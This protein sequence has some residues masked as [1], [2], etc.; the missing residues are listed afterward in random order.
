MVGASFTVAAVAQ[1]LRSK[2]GITAVGNAQ[3]STAQSQFGGSSALFDASAD[4]LVITNTDDLNTGT[5]DFTL[6]FWMRP[7]SRATNFPV[8]I[9]NRA[10]QAGCIQ[11]T[12]R[13][14][15]N[16][17]KLQVWV[18]NY[19]NAD[20]MFVSTTT[21]ANNTWY[22]IAVSRSGSSWR[23]F[24]NGTQEGSTVTYSGDATVGANNFAA[25]GNDATNTSVTQWN[26]YI[27]EVRWSKTARYTSNFTPSTTAFVNDANTLFL[28][29]ANGTDAS[30]FFEDDNGVRAQVGIGASGTVVTSTTQSKFGGTS[31]YFDGG[32]TDH[33]LT[34]TDAPN[35]GSGNFT[36]EFWIYPYTNSAGNSNGVVTKRVVGN[37]GA[38]AWG[39]RW[40]DSGTRTIVW[41]NIISPVTT[42]T[43]SANPFNYNAWSHWAFVRNGSTLT[44]YVNGTS[45]GSGS[46]SIDFTNSEPIRLGWWGTGTTTI[47]AYVD[48]IRISNSARYTT[49]FTPSTTP[50]TNDANTVLLIHANG[51]NASTVFRDDNGARAPK[52]IQ[53]I[54]NAQIDT[55]QSKFGG[56]SLL[57]D[58]TDDRLEIYPTT[59]YDDF[60]VECWIR[61]AN[62]SGTKNI[63]AFG[64][65]STGR[66]L[67][68]VY[69]DR[70]H[71]DQYGV[72]SRHGN[73]SMSANT[74]Y[75]L[76]WSRTGS[77]IK[78]FV[79]G[80]EQT[81]TTVSG[82]GTFPSGAV[83][84]TNGIFIGTL[85][86]GAI[87]FNGH[88]DEIRVS[89]SVRYSA[90]FS[91]PTTPFQND[92]NTLLLLHMDGTDASTVFFDDN[93]IA[94]YTP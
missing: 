85:S 60:T 44:I 55:A 50:F 30:T 59:T 25:I 37:V 54:G 3:I 47:G 6:E 90:G 80:V 7:I 52:G 92:A 46:N 58:G 81:M 23:L 9:Q 32:G 33:L 72:T 42:I 27:D 24:V 8:V 13:H 31:A 88:I 74:W 20:P 43:S 70:I 78:L 57:L 75:H 84:N 61:L 77:T 34:G 14:N 21:I 65:E 5:G 38:G 73:T 51:T 40:A 64:N 79:D 63:L 45:V 11:I 28:M 66:L 39:I 49:T 17:S 62:N 1:V 12:D 68:A 10:F 56:A 69:N 4:W 93:G 18:V 82:S 15:Y 29:H 19:S 91:A 86:D 26:G 83:G 87:D 67:F 22:H 94:P 35:L 41:E 16:T 2:K 71:W 53:A 89:N 36:V 76:A 48:E